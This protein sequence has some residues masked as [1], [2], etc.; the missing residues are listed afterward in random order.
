[1]GFGTLYYT[2]LV[3][4]GFHPTLAPELVGLPPNDM[5]MLR[6]M[7]SMHDM[8]WDEMSEWDKMEMMKK[9]KKMKNEKMD[10]MDGDKMDM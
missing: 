6:K 3:Y 5:D 10:G 9:Y 7:V 4:Q 8:E 1:M 2:D